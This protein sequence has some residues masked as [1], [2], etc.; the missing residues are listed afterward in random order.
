M[1]MYSYADV[2]E[3]MGIIPMHCIG[4]PIHYIGIT[5]YCID[6]KMY[7]IIG[8]TMYKY[9]YDDDLIHR[10]TDTIHRY[11]DTMHRYTDTIHRYTHTHTNIGIPIHIHRYNDVYLSLVRRF[12]RYADDKYINIPMYEWSVYLWICVVITKYVHRYTDDLIYLHIDKRHRY[13]DIMYRDTDTMHR[14][15]HTHKDIGITI[16][17]HRYNDV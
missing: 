8:I 5:M 4:I 9:R 6:I 15:T 17:A 12:Y 11:T 10:Y 16:H 3:G 2:F 14:Y 7:Q 13:T 1:C